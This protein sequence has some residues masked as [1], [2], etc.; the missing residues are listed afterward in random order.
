LWVFCNVLDYEAIPVAHAPICPEC[1]SYNLR[2]RKRD[3]AVLFFL[4]LVGRWPYACENC[5]TRFFL[6]KRYVRV[7]EGEVQSDISTE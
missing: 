5:G 1:R 6:Q 2:R 7:P 3:S 4:S